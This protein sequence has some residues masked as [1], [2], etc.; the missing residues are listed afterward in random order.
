[1]KSE[2]DARVAAIRM[3]SVDAIE[4]AQS[5]H[6]GMPLGMA[7]IAE[8]LWHDFMRHNPSNPQWHNRDRFVLSNGH[9]SML[10]YTLLHLS[11]YEVS[12]DDLQS[13]RQL[14]SYT[15]GHPEV[16][17]TPGVET[18]T[19]PLGQG[20][21]NAVGMAIMEKN[22]AATFNKDDLTLIDHHTYTFVGDGCLMEGISHE[23]CSL[24]GTL[25]LGKL[26]CFYDDNGISIDGKVDPWFSDNTP[27]RFQA[28][29]WQVIHPVDGHDHQAI[30][31]AI[32]QAKAN[33]E[34]PTLICCQTN[35]GQ[36]APNL[37]GLAKTHGSPLGSEEVQAMRIQLN[38][39]YP[40]F[41]V[42]EDIY[43]TWDRREQGALWENAWR[44]TWRTYQERYP[45]LAHEFN[46]RMQGKLPSDWKDASQNII[47]QVLK[48]DSAMATRKAS[49]YFLNHM[50]PH[51]PE[52]M[53]GSADLT[54]SN[55]TRWDT[56]RT[57]DAD[58]PDGNYLN[59]GVR[60]FGMCAILNGMALRG[61]VIP[62][63]GTFL[64]FSDYAR[65][66][67]RMAALMQQRVIFVLTHDSI[68]LG[69]DGPTHQPVEHLNILRSTPN[70][71]VWRPC[72]LTETTLAWLESLRR[73]TGPSVLALSRQ[74][75]PQLSRSP[76]AVEGIAMG[77][78]ILRDTPEPKAIIIAT[79]SEVPLAIE[80]YEQLHQQG[81]RVRVVSMPCLNQ[82][83][84]QNKSY[85]DHILPPHIECRVAVEAGSSMAWHAIVG[86]QGK[87]LGIDRFGL[88]APG[89][90]VMSAM[91]FTAKRIVSMVKSIL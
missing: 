9:G 16:G 12:M 54:C 72:D 34:Q 78:Y 84:T 41:I 89:A 32:E 70:V 75:L 66:A 27:M 44:Q 5:G 61:G 81:K 53:G 68:A 37:V 51:L 36:G 3:L 25:K 59:F 49:Q 1:M 48:V 22:L 10:L 50:A 71:M 46:R 67:I 90:S 13:F 57:L 38:W 30:A 15:P 85:R 74:N 18:T 83:L 29:N 65:S 82:F 64:V 35:I 52:L 17:E 79:G 8:V 58:T 43:A 63:G 20:L 31:Q 47:K 7:D 73:S 19:G 55:L 24:A 39:A 4:H 2:R 77:G 33:T 42:P 88:S 56:A 11:G 60:E 62:M 40:P 91:D 26:I 87:I 45:D 76:D 69:E 23:V 86:S 14:D 80:A 28:Y 6:P 21:A